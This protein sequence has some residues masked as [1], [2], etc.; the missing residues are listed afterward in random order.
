MRVAESSCE[1][2]DEGKSYCVKREKRLRDEKIY[3]KK[4]KVSLLNE[5]SVLKTR[6]QPRFFKPFL[7]F[8]G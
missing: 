1:T 6:S 5:K 8:A 4:Y 2:R 3:E 7:N